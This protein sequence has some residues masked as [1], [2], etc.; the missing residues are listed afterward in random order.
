MPRPESLSPEELLRRGREAVRAGRVAHARRLLDRARGR[1]ID[2]ELLALIELPTAYVD[3]ETG[4]LDAALSRCSRVLADRGLSEATRALAA[5]QRALLHTRTGDLAA[6]LKDFAVAERGLA[7]AEHLGRLHLNRGNV[8]LQTRQLGPAR[9]DFEAAERLLAESGDPLEA[10]KAGFNQAYAD[11][12]AGDL[13]AALRGMER[14]T[15]VLSSASPVTAAVLAQDR[16][17]A[18]LAA[19]LAEEAE[20][21]LARA[22]KGYAARRLRQY[23][24]EAEIVHARTLLRLGEWTRAVRVARHAARTFRDR[25]S[26]TWALRAD[27]VALGARTRARER[28]SGLLADA[29][30]T[31]E[32]LRSSGLVEEATL[33]ALAGVQIAISRGDVEDAAARRRRVR[34]PAAAGTESRL[35]AREVDARLAFARGRRTRALGHVRSGLADLHAWQ[36][37]FGSVDLQSNVVALG[38]ELARQGLRGAVAG[39]RPEELY[40]WSERARALVNRVTPVRPPVD[41]QVAADL[42]ELR[43]ISTDGAAP[44]GRVRELRRRIREQTWYGEGSRAVAEP[45][46]ADE[47]RESLAGADATLL[48]HVVVDGQ[49]TALVAG[50]GAWS[51]HSLGPYAPVRAAL[52]RVLADLD[53]AASELQPSMRELVHRGLRSGFAALDGLL[54]APLS[55]AV[56]TSRV[57]VTPSSALGGLPWS[58]LP[59]LRG[60]PLTQPRTATRWVRSTAGPPAAVDSVG[61][62]TGPR[63]ARADAEVAAAAGAWPADKVRRVHGAGVA[64]L[65]DLAEEVDVL[66]VAAHGRHSRDTPLF[67]GLEMADG[68]FYGYDVDRVRNIPQVVVLSAC[69]LGRGAVRVP[70]E[71]LG[72]AAA[73]LHAGTRHVVASSS[74]VSDE[75]ARA[76]LARLHQ[77]LAEGAAPADALAS[78]QASAEAGEAPTPFI[79]FGAGW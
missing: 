42:A 72:M 51:M 20:A 34:M 23:Q 68:A 17:E 7:D 48:A 66:H 30:R 35:I 36:S 41:A 43:M 75:A 65:V 12:L 33:A 50:G 28:G 70:E 26:E 79:C 37:S 31:A 49:I 1:T 29:D 46:A 38:R 16:A 74:L 52:D 8:Y 61:F 45:A 39:G 11:L 55:G 13:V 10:A 67:S 69:E 59:S 3:A 4:D 19:G 5:S 62:A 24:A 18:L 57:L 40:E 64:D 73:W 53:I 77:R 78:A 71:S 60:R 63:V 56:A 54:L 76:L 58:S 21:E 22:A 44:S 27:L 2:P 14:V 47:L 25:G 9:E 15:P 32:A 6:A